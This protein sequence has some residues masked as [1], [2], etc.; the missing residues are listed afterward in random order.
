MRIALLLACLAGP[1]TAWEFSDVPV[2][3]LTHTN[4]DGALKLTYDASLPEY[5]ITLT[6]AEGTWPTDAP[7]FAMAFAGARNIGIQT[8]QHVLSPDGRSLTVTDTGF[9]NVLDGLEF[10]LR[11]YASAG[12]T[13][14]GFNLTDIGP[15]IRAFRACPDANLA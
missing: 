14:V 8:D 5:T 3:T 7:A 11:A 13:T 10:N 1:A 4:E 6:L 12:E 2:C 15:A 9:G